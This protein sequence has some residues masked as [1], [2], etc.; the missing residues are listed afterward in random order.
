MNVGMLAVSQTKQ[1][2]PPR[3][4]RTTRTTLTTRTTATSYH[5]SSRQF[6]TPP[7]PWST[8]SYHP[9][10]PT[11]QPLAN[12][13]PACYVP[14]CYDQSKQT[15]VSFTNEPDSM[16]TK[17]GAAATAGF[18]CAF[19]SLPFGELRINMLSFTYLRYPT[20]YTPTP[21]TPTTKHH[22]THQL[23]PDTCHIHHR[24]DQIS[25]TVHET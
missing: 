6:T 14:Q 15:I 2:V 17:L 19:M 13:I 4:T 10:D 3:T 1:N 16:R 20:A 18:F 8:S 11:F 25:P 12:P 22:P 7:K 21:H 23:T 5:I 9:V 24:H